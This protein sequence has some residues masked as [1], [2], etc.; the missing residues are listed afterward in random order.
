MTIP[1]TLGL[2]RTGD[3][4]LITSMPVP[5]LEK[6]VERVV[7]PDIHL[8]TD[9]AQL[10]G[11][12]DT[13]RTAIISGSLENRSFSI[14]LHNK[15]SGKLTIGYNREVA[16]FFVDRSESGEVNFSKNFQTLSH[17]PRLSTSSTIH[18]T[19]VIDVASVEAFF[20]DGETVMTS[21]FYA[22]DPLSNC[23]IKSPG[24]LVAENL[25]ISYLR[26]VGKNVFEP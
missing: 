9:S 18:F 6:L 17:A 19:L 26:S 2:S 11:P 12:E 20:D 16:Q 24:P 15:K 14:E 25:K 5:E 22:R 1:R 4:F 13:I 3:H 7:F 23:T 10:T 8:I 21:V